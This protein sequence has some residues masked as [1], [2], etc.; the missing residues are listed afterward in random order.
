MVLVA[1]QGFPLLCAYVLER[2]EA[3]YLG[4]VREK[5]H[6]FFFGRRLLEKNVDERETKNNAT[7]CT[8]RV[9]ESTD[10]GECQ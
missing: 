3:W 4:S 2:V 9:Q 7:D 1:E 5:L 10:I 6:P 8:R